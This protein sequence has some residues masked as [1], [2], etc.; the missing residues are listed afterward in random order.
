MKYDLAQEDLEDFEQEKRIQ[1]WL[2]SQGEGSDG[3]VFAYTTSKGTARSSRVRASI[4][5]DQKI[6][7]DSGSGTFAD[8]VA[9]SDGRDLYDGDDSESA[10]QAQDIIRA[11]LRALNFTEDLQEWLVKTLKSSI[12]QSKSLFETYLTDSEW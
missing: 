5:L 12:S 3:F 1:E 6:T 11:Y 2:A 4:S 9:G 7:E 10:P 8:L